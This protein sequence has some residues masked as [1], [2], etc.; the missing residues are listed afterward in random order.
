MEQ[1]VLVKDTIVYVP[2]NAIVSY[3]PFGWSSYYESYSG[4]YI[5]TDDEIDAASYFKAADS[6]PS[7][8][9]LPISCTSIR[10]CR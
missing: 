4:V 10:M 7:R 2:L 9:A 8:V 1:P 6:I 5:N 3:E